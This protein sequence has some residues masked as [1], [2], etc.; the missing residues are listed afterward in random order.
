MMRT[1]PRDLDPVTRLARLGA[2]DDGLPRLLREAGEAGEQVALLHVDLDDF[3]SINE[4]MGEDV[5]D[6]ALAAVAQRLAD[7][8]GPRGRVWRLTSD[9]FIVALPYA[10]GAIEPLRF[11]DHLREELEVPLQV[12]PYTLQVGGSVGVAVHPEDAASAATLLAAAETAL[13]QARRR[14][15]NRSARY[16]RAGFIPHARTTSQARRI[17]DA[18]GRDELEVHYQPFLDAADGR[19]VGVEALLR[20]NSP[21][22]GLVGPGQFMPIAEKLGLMA[23][24]GSWVVEQ[25]VQQARRWRV[26][27]LD[28]LKVAIN[29]ST[30]QLMQTDF[31]DRLEATLAAADVPF[32]QFEIELSEGTLN[33]NV[34][35][36]R[37]RL[38]RLRDQGMELT[39]DDFGIGGAGLVNLPRYPLNKLK[40]D[41]GFVSEVAVDASQ[42][43]IA[44]AIIAMGHQMQ[45]QVMAE[46]VET[47]AQVG[48]LR[49]NHCDQ[50]QGYL[51]G[52]PASADALEQVLRRRYLR[53]ELFAN[54]SAG[55]TL[56]LLD[57][58]EN[59]LRALLRVFRREG[60]RILTASRVQ[61]AFELLATNEVQVILSDQRMSDMSGTEFLG[62][63]KELYPDTVRMV[64]S[65]YTDLAT[66]TDAINR[67][68]I[69]RFLT[70]PWEDDELRAHIREAFRTHDAAHGG[71]RG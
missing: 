38:R 37:E 36:V 29:L 12:I 20:W 49:R 2:E 67:G 7:V 15:L 24:I 55:R 23:G 45:M 57:D 60:Y 41:R 33:R 66:V 48:F 30:A 3:G 50:L 35:R 64:L 21:E 31:I 53:P 62:R 16:S 10:P 70:K 22:H 5:G 17:G 14:G 4:S 44:R 25:V 1:P 28:D 61:E 47:E 8:A 18:I 46:G 71:G 9:E 27:G 68:A 43:A 39:L 56:L 51:F 6:L 69:Y 63:V 26:A 65:G 32:R 58:E 34:A 52:P 19:I 42:A 11:A 40:I 13:G 54:T 59:V